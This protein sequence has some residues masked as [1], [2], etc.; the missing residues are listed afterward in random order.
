MAQKVVVTNATSCYHCG[1]VCAE[2]IVKLDNKSFCCPGCKAVYQLFL[3]TDLQDIYKETSRL[4]PGASDKYDYLDNETVKNQVLDFQSADHNSFSVKL[5][6]IHCSSCIYLIENLHLFNAAI[7]RVNVNFVSK[8]ADIHYNPKL[9][10]LKEL[11]SLL[12]TLGY[13]PQ[14]EQDKDKKTR[15]SDLSIKIGVAAFC[16]G[17][18]MLLSFPEYLGFEAQIDQSF[19]VFFSY[20]NIALA[21]PVL[22]YA[23][24]DY[25]RSAYRGLK[26][27]FI[28]IDVPIALGIVALFGR[29]LYE[30]I[31]HTGAG[32]LDSLAGLVFFLLIGKWFQSK[33]YDNLSFERDY[34]SY[35]PLAA[36]RIIGDE[37]ESVPIA[38]LKEGDQVMIRNQE[39]I[40]AD[41]VLQ[42]D[43]ANIDYGFVTGEEKPV[44]K[45]K[46]EILYAGGKQVGASIIIKITKPSSQSYLTS[47]WNNQIFNQSKTWSTEA[48][49]N[50]ISKYFT[51]II[52]I[53]A[54]SAAGYWYVVNADNMWQVFTAVLIVAC[55]CALALSAPFTNGHVLRVLGRNKCYLKNALSAEK[56]NRINT[57]V[58]DKT[59]TLTK[60]S[61]GKVQ[62]FGNTLTDQEITWIKNL[63]ENSMH[64]V[65]QK[66]HTSLECS[67]KK[68]H[69]RYFQEFPG[70][71]IKGTIDS[72]ELALGRAAFIDNKLP[73]TAG[74]VYLA[75]DGK[76]RGYFEAENI[77]REGIK[78]LVQA[79]GTYELIVLSGD[80]DQE[81][82][83]LNSIFPAHTAMHF[84]QAP[85]DKLAYIKKL[86]EAGK[87]VM[88]LGDGLND[89][90]ALKQSDVGIAVTEDTATFS[91]ACDGIL[92]GDRLRHLFRFLS[93][94]RNGRQIIIWSFVISF[95]YNAV[96]LSFAVTGV[97]TPL[98]AAVLMPLSS[99]SV[100][101]FTFF[102]S[103]YFAR[104]KQ[105]R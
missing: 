21:L 27:K 12:D 32:Y 80:N 71:G 30:I 72:H 92:K 31:T 81:R 49:T 53:I 56:L 87:K 10:S 19:K 84:K 60:T 9:A 65:S 62:F 1:D 4:R 46:G 73:Q 41:A 34:K 57:I 90:G 5:P 105:L 2:E 64:P 59:G 42:S 7:I 33:T 43:I 96:G 40:P 102:A 52:L 66:I 88:M 28:N 69:V 47:L 76:V 86:Q 11:A 70:S 3:D 85:H 94:A 100:V 78:D 97:L 50:K 103:N 101:G 99:I 24:S 6:A 45:R 83:M 23:A 36:K 104:K 22:F 39:I 15:K 48:I 89:A 82:E 91:P 8:Q 17:N 79:L 51:L 68:K 63:T 16:F 74:R 35:F 44:S 98:F 29:S 67:S 26:N 55:P 93:F 38:D 61:T 54:I 37:Q 25:F 13:V 20:L 18:I 75:I 58:F 77:Y 14:F 95:L